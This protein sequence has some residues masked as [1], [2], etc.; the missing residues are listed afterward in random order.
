MIAF[1]SWLVFC[2][3][4]AF[5]AL[6]WVRLF[7]DGFAPAEPV[8]FELEC[9]Y[10]AVVVPSHLIGAHGCEREFAVA[11]DPWGAAR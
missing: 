10:C 1:L 4:M 8:V 3:F 9:S 5:L 11:G 7:R 2:G 6:A